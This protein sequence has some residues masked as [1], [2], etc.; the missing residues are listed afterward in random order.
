MTDDQLKILMDVYRDRSILDTKLLERQSHFIESLDRS[1]K[2]LIEAIDS[3]T[4]SVHS[5]LTAGL[6]AMGQK[7]TEEHGS[8]S[9]RLYIAM[10]G[11]I[12]IIATLIAMWVTK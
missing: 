2:R 8:L 9:L 7:I 1:T 5:T 12:S 11:M 10:G 4:E 6:A 3:Q